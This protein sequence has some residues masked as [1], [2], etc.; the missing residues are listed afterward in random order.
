VVPCVVT[1][2]LYR[3]FVPLVVTESLNRYLVIY[4]VTQSLNRD[5]DPCEVRESLNCC[6]DPCAIAVDTGLYGCRGLLTNT[7]ERKMEYNKDVHFHFFLPER[8]G[9]L[10]S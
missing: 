10:F 9:K 7:L 1:E 5:L 6:L 2:S 8:L 3:S 4:A